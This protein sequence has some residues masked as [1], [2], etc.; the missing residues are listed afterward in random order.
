MNKFQLE[1]T[2]SYI[3]ETFNERVLE[4]PPQK[5]KKRVAPVSVRLSAEERAMLEE[6][7]GGLSLSAHIRERLFGEEVKPRKSRRRTPVKDHKS[8]AKV[9]RLL[10]ETNLA[11]DLESLQW[12]V[13][14]GQVCLSAKSEEL[15]RLACVAVIEM[16]KDVLRALG[17]R[18]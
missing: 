8:L 15:L 14:E 4:R 10:G 7:A 3:A 18:P 16:R 11:R 6:Q 5:K 13:E 1:D 9:L 17:L 12:S 2:N